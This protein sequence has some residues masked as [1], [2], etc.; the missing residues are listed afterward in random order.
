[1]FHSE[2]DVADVNFCRTCLRNYM[3][4]TSETF[5][6]LLPVIKQLIELQLYIKFKYR[7]RCAKDEYDDGPA[8]YL[9][10]HGAEAFEE[11]M[12][13]E[14][15]VR[16]DGVEEVELKMEEIEDLVYIK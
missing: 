1:Y 7:E 6:L 2:Q 10:K 16:S 15:G 8:Y 5:E 11:K 13:Q 14:E 3:C 12:R 9:A 4:L